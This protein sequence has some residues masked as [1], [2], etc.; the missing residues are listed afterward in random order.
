MKTKL[1]HGTINDFMDATK[2]MKRCKTRYNDHMYASKD[3]LTFIELIS[4]DHDEYTWCTKH[5]REGKSIIDSGYHMIHTRRGNRLPHR[6]VAEAWLLPDDDFFDDFEVD[7]LDGDKTNN[8]VENLDIV[9]HKENMARAWK[10]GLIAKPTYKG[11]YY[12]KTETFVHPNGT[13]EHMT[14]DEYIAWRKKN[15]L[16]IKGWMTSYMEV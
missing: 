15:C 13:R 16:P 9:S 11:R 10:N 4:I 1:N 7:H 14:P 5:I 3:G 8:S 2:D 12:Q 6:L